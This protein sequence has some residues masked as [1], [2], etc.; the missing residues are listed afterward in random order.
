M[1]NKTTQKHLLVETEEE[2][3]PQTDNHNNKCCYS[4]PQHIIT[5]QHKNTNYFN[6]EA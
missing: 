4:L 3:N 5:A 1:L 6:N 2:E